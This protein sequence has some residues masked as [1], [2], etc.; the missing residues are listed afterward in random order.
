LSENISKER[1]SKAFADVDKI[2]IETGIKGLAEHHDCYL[3][4]V[5]KQE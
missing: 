2:A 4:G 3:Y 1:K 5:S